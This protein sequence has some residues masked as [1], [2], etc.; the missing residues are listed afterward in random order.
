MRVRQVGRTGSKW[1]PVRYRTG[2][3]ALFRKEPVSL[4]I[5]LTYPDEPPTGRHGPL[6]L[7]GFKHRVT[8]E[9]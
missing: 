2:A 1:A 8:N 4:G 7:A 9:P 3:R 6:D 5:E